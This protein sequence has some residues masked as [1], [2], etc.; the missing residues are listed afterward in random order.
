MAL[1]PRFIHIECN[2][3][4]NPNDLFK[5]EANKNATHRD[6]QRERERK[7]KRDIDL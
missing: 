2:V 7:T 4:R 1:E 6:K 3:M 5:T